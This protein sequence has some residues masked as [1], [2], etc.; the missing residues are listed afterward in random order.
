MMDVDDFFAH[1]GVKGMKWGVRRERREGSERQPWSTKKK[2]LV[3]AAVVAGLA[4]VAIG[5]K[6]GMDYASS[7]KQYTKLLNADSVSPMFKSTP[8]LKKQYEKSLSISET[9]TKGHE[10]IRR[11]HVMETRIDSRAYASA[12]KEWAKNYG[13]TDFGNNVMSMI[14][15]SNVRVPSYRQGIDAMSETFSKKELLGTLNRKT[16]GRRLYQNTRLKQKDLALLAY[17]NIEG[18]NFDVSKDPI[19]QKYFE[20]MTRRG[21][22]AV[23]DYLDG[24]DAYVLF[25]NSVFDIVKQ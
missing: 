12:S 19:V 5:T 11:S 15:K 1:H 3:G 18:R 2:V 25:N 8:S 10:F 21:Y 22:S 9:I 4:G 6:V 7:A 16:L 17:R 14:T 24:G 20:T 13:S 23:R